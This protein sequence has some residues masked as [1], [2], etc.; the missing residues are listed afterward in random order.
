MDNNTLPSFIR[1]FSTLA[2]MVMISLLA[3]C[4]GGGSDR[5]TTPDAFTFTDVTD[6][7]RGVQLTSGA[8]TISG[9]NRET[10]ISITGGEYAI[11]G[12][13]YTSAAGQVSNGQ[14]V[15]VRLTSS[16]EFSTA[17]TATVTI[18]EVSGAYSVT[19]LAAD[20]TP[21]AFTFTAV[22]DA[23][24]NTEYSTSAFNVSGIN[25]N[26]DISI[27]GGEYA[28]NSSGFVSAAGQV[29]NGDAIV[30]R[31]TSSPETSTETIAT[32]TIGGVSDDFSV[33][34]FDDTEAPTASIVFPPP[35]SLTEGTSILVR[36]TASDN[37]GVTSLSV[38]GI[39]AVTNDGFATWTVDVPLTPD[40]SNSLVVTVNDAAGNE[41]AAAAQA[42]IESGNPEFFPDIGT[43][44]VNL[45]GLAVDQTNGNN[46]LLVSDESQILTV[47]LDTGIRGVLASALDNPMFSFLSGITTDAVNGRAI[48]VDEGGFAV[49]EVDLESGA[50]TLISANGDPDA[51]DDFDQPIDVVVDEQNNRLLVIDT[52]VRALFSVNLTVG[53]NYGERTI[54]SSNTVP[55]VTD[56][57][58]SPSSMVIDS[59]NNRVIITAERDDRFFEVATNSGEVEV[60]SD[61]NTPDSIFIGTLLAS[62]LDT[63][64]NRL[65][66]ID[67][68]S[69]TSELNMGDVAL[70]DGPGKGRRTLISDS[71][72][73][74]TNI[75]HDANRRAGMILVG[76]VAYV[77]NANQITV[78]DLVTGKRAILSRT[79]CLIECP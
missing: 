34:T 51:V 38:N 60:V 13:A 59:S 7:E 48:V 62:A 16:S 36:G 11:G 40:I 64:N 23:E 65:L 44:F 25:T 5:D 57:Y 21:D 41:D 12:G 79:T 43:P 77:A 27:T 24:L 72:T 75:T 52:D 58:I 39:D 6:V 37:V 45:G 32:L 33:T 74:L 8:I 47:S 66:Y 9:I 31:Q 17:A 50:T 3:A 49:Y 1:P 56:V 30:V 22:T 68:A 69:T 54:F 4:G 10:A 53:P 71:T 28:I 67:R 18:G 73:D 26:A 46:R 78:Y 42:T 55:D 2:L 14:S 76:D 15:T 70:V 63:A 35:V 20:T 29:A 19:T 61:L